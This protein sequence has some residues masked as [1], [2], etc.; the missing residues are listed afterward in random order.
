MNPK[1]R[2]IHFFLLSK[3]PLPNKSSLLVL[4][5]LNVIEAQGQVRERV[6]GWKS[7]KLNPQA[8]PDGLGDLPLSEPVFLSVK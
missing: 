1:S 4:Y 5:C 7:G 6:L 8:L 2:K 3:D